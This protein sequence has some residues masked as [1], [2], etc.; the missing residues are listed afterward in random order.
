[1]WNGNPE[2]VI[3]S[4]LDFTKPDIEEQLN[5]AR[6]LKD[7]LAAKFVA[8]SVCACPH[9]DMQNWSYRHHRSKHTRNSY[10]L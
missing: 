10:F 6:Q 5:Q 4:I 8:S 1:M 2:H 9:I 3:D 7:A